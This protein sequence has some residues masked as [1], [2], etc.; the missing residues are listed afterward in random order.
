MSFIYVYYIY[1]VDT[2][3]ETQFNFEKCFCADISYLCTKL[4]PFCLR[5]AD[6][7]SYMLLM[8]ALL[9]LE[10]QKNFI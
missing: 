10:V 1:Y 9:A 8:R 6:C 4:G 5:R 7:L 2:H 3:R